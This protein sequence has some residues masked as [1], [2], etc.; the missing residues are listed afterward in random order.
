[1]EDTGNSLKPALKSTQW[2]YIAVDRI[3]NRYSSI[4]RVLAVQQWI[5]WL[6]MAQNHR[7]IDPDFSYYAIDTL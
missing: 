3:P 1:M 4:F 6:K 5:K 7:K 2:M